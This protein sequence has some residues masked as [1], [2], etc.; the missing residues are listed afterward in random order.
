MFGYIGRALLYHY[1]FC[2]SEERSDVRI[3]GN[4]HLIAVGAML[5]MQRCFCLSAKAMCANAAM[6]VFDTLW[7]CDIAISH[8]DKSLFCEHVVCFVF[9]QS[10]VASDNRLSYAC[11]LL[12][13][14]STKV[15]FGVP[16]CFVFDQS[17]AVNVN[18]LSFACLFLF[19]TGTK[20]SRVGFIIWFPSGRC[21]ANCAFEIT[22]SGTI[23][24]TL[25][26]VCA[27]SPK[28]QSIFWGPHNGQCLAMTESA[29]HGRGQRLW[30][31]FNAFPKH[32]LCKK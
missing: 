15:S 17:I 18:C 10:I 23:T 27:F 7:Y 26:L 30:Y 29:S 2:H 21:G 28:V 22:L 13:P 1:A 14:K 25:F 4:G 5:L 11:I 19:P 16:D 8:C 32:F 9:D 31:I 12:F 3:A 20:V 24:L 6:C